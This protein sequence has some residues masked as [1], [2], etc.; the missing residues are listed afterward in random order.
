MICKTPDLYLIEKSINRSLQLHRRLKAVFNM[1]V[2]IFFILFL[3]N[4]YACIFFTISINYKN[5]HNIPTGG[6]NCWIDAVKAEGLYISEHLWTVQ[7]V[8]SLYWASTTMLTVG[9][10]DVVPK[11]RYE[12]LFDIVAEF[13]SCLVFA[14]SVNKIWEIKNELNDKKEKYQRKSN[15]INRFMRDKNVK[16]ELRGKVNAYLVHFYTE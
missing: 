2:L 6:D 7:Y 10:G 14:Y 5:M 4:A 13:T 15:L 11:N 12:V 16:S 8:Y 1:S 9:Y 3:C